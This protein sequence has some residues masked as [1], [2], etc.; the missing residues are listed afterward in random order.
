MLRFMLCNISRRL[1]SGRI[2]NPPA[3]ILIFGMAT[4]FQSGNS[5]CEVLSRMS[6]ANPAGE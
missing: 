4:K 1:Y 3:C 2:V 6:A 5:E